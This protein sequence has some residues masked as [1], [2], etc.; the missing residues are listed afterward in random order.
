MKYFVQRIKWNFQRI[1]RERL[2]GKVKSKLKN[3]Q[4]SIISQNCIGGVFYHDM[5][6]KF[7]SPTINL[8]F[9]QPDFVRFVLEIEKYLSMEL[10]MEWGEEYPVGR[11]GDITIHFMHYESCTEAEKSWN[12]RKERVNLNKIIVLS[13]DME[14]FDDTVFEMWNQI[15]YPKVLFTAHKEYIQEKSSVYFSKYEVFNQ[16]LDLIP[17]REFYKKNILVDVVNKN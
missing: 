7:L 10:L 13:T 2:I 12:K 4:F 6:I 15:M 11:L 1:K 9:E 14:G 5:G 8:Y 17:K 16:V 3:K